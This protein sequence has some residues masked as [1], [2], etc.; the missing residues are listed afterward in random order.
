[1]LYFVMNTINYYYHIF[2]QQYLHAYELSSL[3][4]E[5]L[6]PFKLAMI[7]D[8]LLYIHNLNNAEVLFRYISFH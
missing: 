2:F 8:L 5:F 3:K 1:M 7:I 6:I 4:C